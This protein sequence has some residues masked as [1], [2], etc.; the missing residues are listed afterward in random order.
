[1]K[2]ATTSSEEG[3]I[4]GRI[5]TAEEAGREIDRARGYRAELQLNGFGRDTWVEIHFDWVGNPPKFA[6]EHII[7]DEYG[8]SIMLL[9][10]TGVGLRILDSWHIG[11][12]KV[13][14]QEVRIVD[15]VGESRTEY[16]VPL[17]RARY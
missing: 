17:G 4:R 10:T 3:A 11:F 5:V 7:I 2:D 16:F 1:M 12:K 14:R 9:K 13:G 8:P 6:V 15:I